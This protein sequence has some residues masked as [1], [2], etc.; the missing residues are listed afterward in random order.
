MRKTWL[1]LLLATGILQWG[2]Q[3]YNDYAGVPFEEKQPA[4]WENP[5]V[6]EINREAPRAWFVPFATPEEVD[7]DNIWASSFM[8]SLNGEWKF[9]YSDKPSERP[10][11]FFKDD[12]DT[13]KWPTIPVPSNFELEGYTY[14]IYTNVQYPHEV[15]PP[16]IQDHYNPVGSYK[17]EFSLPENW[18][19][20]EIYLHFGAVSSAMYVWVNEQQVGYSQDS[21]TPAVFNITPYLKSGTNTLAVEVY[22]WSDGSYLEDQ[23]FW[24]LGG[25]TRDVYLQARNATHI[26]D[27]SVSSNLDDD[28]STGLFGLEVE[29]GG[30]Q[31]GSCSV[32]AL[33]ND[34]TQ[35]LESFS[36]KVENGSV[37]FDASFP[38]VKRW[39]AETPALYELLI[40]LKNDQNQVLEVLRQEVGFRRVEI[41]GN[42]LL[43]NGEYIYLKGA[44]LHEHHEVTGHV[45]DEGTMLEDIRIMKMHNLNAVRTSHY[46]QAERFYELCNRYGLYVIDEA[47]IESHGM[48]Y[49]ERSLAKDSTWK[50]AH[51]FR[52][53]NMYERDK[54]QPSIIIWSLGN[55]AGNGVNFDAA[56]DY[57]KAADNSRPVQYEQAHGG[58]NTDI[59]APMYASIERMIRYA[60]EDGSKPLIQCEYA[61]AMG[62]SVGNLQDYWD[63]IEAHEV[64]QGG[65]IWDWV[66]QGLLTQDEEG[67]PF[68]AYGGDFGPDTV[69]SDGNFCINGLVDPDR[70]IKPA[71]LEVKKVYQYLKFHPENLAR[72][73]I[74]IENKY[75][76][77]STDRFVFN[78]DIK[79]DG[80]VVAS[81]VFNEVQL[82]P[83]EKIKVQAD[84]NF[85]LVPGTEYFLTVSAS[86]K[87]DDGLVPAGTV[88]AAEQFEL[89]IY[90]AAPDKQEQLPALQID[91]QEAMINIQ[92]EGFSVSFDKTKG[93]LTS[94]KL[95][96]KEMLMSGPE[97]V[98]WRAPI[99]NDFGNDM[100]VRS[101][102]WR[103]AGADRKVVK[104]EVSSPTEGQVQIA[105]DFELPNK[106]GETIATYRSTYVVKGDQSIEVDNHFAMASDELPEIPRMGM[107]LIMPREFDQMTWLGRGPHESYQDRKTSAFVDRYSASVA[108]QYYA[109]VRPQE[110]GNKTDVRWM[111]VTNAAGEGLLFK[112][113]Q[114]LEVSAHHNVL[115]DFESPLRSDGRLPEGERPVQRHINDVVERDL[116]AVDIDLK[117]MGLGGDTSWGAWTHTQYRL[118]E[119]AYSYGF[120][121][122]P[123]K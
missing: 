32:E 33:L 55:E 27:F 57:L 53:R 62:N 40:T 115:E 109:Y 38:D 61:H 111:S 97:P 14:P 92:G 104:A 2:C 12:F 71:L 18:D 112:G 36:G 106:E 11:Y 70:G 51:V 83:D 74:G 17:R 108:D 19:G 73:M 13:R 80:E 15:T 30:E 120:T 88:L 54:N 49:G 47:N 42:T 56:Y 89:P 113:K 123:A 84:M 64:M 102:M 22:K 82:A 85:D 81:G 87:E 107:T 24:R 99:D 122:A 37:A 50:A 23:D 94:Y 7:A 117:Q 76:F 69:P 100:P 63:V 26:K 20:K 91:D 16:T 98:L 44:N 43:V 116:T 41:K 10:F 101:R 34:G 52:V 90:Q 21:K 59:F 45:M 60:N 65:F 6:N 110:N 93:Q 118:T 8:H 3:S 78:W 67:R 25:I 29:V 46:P 72:G 66:D 105:F 39:S 31:A 68:W 119:K 86:L 35:T 77:I 114:L 28:Y 95:G 96:E 103:E 79:G 9:M 121:I 75:D 1:L 4:D 58:R 48:G 5:A